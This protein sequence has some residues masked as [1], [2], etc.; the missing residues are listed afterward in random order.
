MNG[1][2]E[3]L[4]CYRTKKLNLANIFLHNDIKTIDI[5]YEKQH[6]PKMCTDVGKFIDSE[7]KLNIDGKL[8][9]VVQK[10]RLIHYI[11]EKKWNKNFSVEK[12]KIPSKTELVQRHGFHH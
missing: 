5:D 10:Y 3:L 9:P 1:K 4:L 7:V 12:I 2:C 8:L 6:F 11:Y